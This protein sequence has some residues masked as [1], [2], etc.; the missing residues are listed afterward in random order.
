[1]H[2]YLPRRAAAQAALMFALFGPCAIVL[3]AE[4]PWHSEGTANGIAIFT[5]EVPGQPLRDFKGIVQIDAPMSQVAATLADVSTMH[6]WFFLLREARFVRGAYTLDSHMYM[7]IKGI[8]PMSP[9]DVVARVVVRQD[10]GTLAIHI[11]AQNEDGIMPPQADHVRIPK[12][13]SSWTLR[14]A[15]GGQTEVHLEGHGDPGGW[16]PLSIANFVVTTLPRQCLEKLRL[17]VAK[18]EYRD[19]DKVYAKNPK[20]RELAGKLVFPAP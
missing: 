12:M 9:R 17:H 13:R 11:E 1:M 15:P 18:P 7:S 20:L 19:M 8:W 5:R 2:P 10:P 4:V 3:A 14:P 6:E 16:I